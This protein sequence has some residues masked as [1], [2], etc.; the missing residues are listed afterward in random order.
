MSSLCT[1]LTQKIKVSFQLEDDPERSLFLAVG[2]GNLLK[3]LLRC[4]SKLKFKI[5]TIGGL[6]SL[7]ELEEE[8]QLRVM[9]VGAI[10]RRTSKI[11]FPCPFKSSREM[12][13][14]VWQFL[15]S[16]FCN[17]YFLNLSRY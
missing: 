11:N 1:I 4:Y 12:D 10:S 6:F 8:E 13:S 16:R 14:H 7:K 3:S 15:L 5:V 9:V 2:T 17:D